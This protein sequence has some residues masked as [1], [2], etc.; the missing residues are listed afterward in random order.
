VTS[1]EPT[2]PTDPTA[3]TDPTDPTDQT[4]RPPSGR[5][6]SGRPPSGRSGQDWRL[7]LLV[8]WITSMVEGMGVSQI[9]ALVPTYLRE[10]GVV[11]EDRIAFVGLFS[12][13]IFVVGLPLVPAARLRR[14]RRLIRA[15][16]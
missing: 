6:P 10:M 4:D 2:D 11:E 14:E 16:A 13:L 1:T 9:F 5:P 3:P 12:S 7:L 15:P 8:F